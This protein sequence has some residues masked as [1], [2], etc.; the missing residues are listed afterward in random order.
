MQV[1]LDSAYRFT[2][3]PD[4]RPT[5]FRG[6]LRQRQNDVAGESEQHQPDKRLHSAQPDVVQILPERS[7]P[8]RETQNE[9]CEYEDR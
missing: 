7:F 4:G 9:R 5:A 1:G 2:P 3:G 6:G 8:F